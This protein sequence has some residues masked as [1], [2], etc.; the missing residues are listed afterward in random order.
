M[1][2]AFT[3]NCGGKQGRIF[4]LS[5]FLTTINEIVKLQFVK[6]NLKRVY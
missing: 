2:A 4:P 6:I 1:A 3:Q 5:V